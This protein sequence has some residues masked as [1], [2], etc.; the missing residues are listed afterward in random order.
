MPLRL[1]SAAEWQKACEGPGGAGVAKWS[2]TNPTTYVPN[3]CNDFKN[4]DGNAASVV[5]SGVPGQELRLNGL[6]GFTAADVGRS[7]FITG[8]A[9]A[10]WNNKTFTIAAVNSST[11]VNLTFAGAVAL[12][13]NNPNIVW[14]V[15]PPVWTTGHAGS[16]GMCYTDW[17]AAGQIHDLSGNLSEWTGTPVID[18]GITYYK[19]R[20]GAYDTPPGG[21]T[22]E[23]DFELGQ[24][25]FANADV[26]FRCCADNPSCG[27]VTSDPNNCGT[28][29]NVCPAV[30]SNSTC[31]PSCD[32][33]LT[34]CSNA[35]VN[36]MT[37][38]NNC[39]ACTTSSVSHACGNGQT[40]VAGVCTCPTGMNLCSGVCV[41]EQTDPNHCGSCTTICSG[42]T[43]DCQAGVCSGACGGATPTNCSGACVNTTS[44]PNHCGSCTNVCGAGSQCVSGACCT[45]T[46]CSGQCVNTLTDGTNCGTCGTNCVTLLGANAT[47]QNGMCC[48][49]GFVNCGGTCV[50][51]STNHDNCNACGNVCPVG[52]SC[53]NGSCCGAGLLTCGAQCVNPASDNN[54]C[55]DCF[56]VCPSN[57][58]CTACMG[59][60]CPQPGGCCAAGQT[61]CSGTCVDT[62]TNNNNCGGC[63]IQCGGGASCKNG[64]C[65]CGPYSS[66]CS[67]T[68]T[69]AAA[70][71]GL[72]LPQANINV[73]STKGFSNLGGTISVTTGAGV[74]TVT[75]QR[76]VGNQFQGC[77]GGT[78]T[79]S[80]GGAVNNGAAQCIPT[81]VDPNNCGGCGIVCGAGTS[82]SNGACV[83]TCNANLFQFTTLLNACSQSCVDQTD[84]RI[85]CGGS[86]SLCP[87]GQGCN[88]GVCGAGIVPFVKDPGGIC[89]ANGLGPIILLTTNGPPRTGST[90]SGSLA[91]TT[92]TFGMCGCSNF[93]G[94]GS[95]AVDGWDSEVDPYAVGANSGCGATPPTGGCQG[96]SFG[97]NASAAISSSLTIS[98]DLVGF[99]NVSAG[100]AVSEQVHIG[101]SDAGGKGGNTSGGLA[102]VKIASNNPGWIVGNG[103]GTTI[104][105]ATNGKVLPQATITVVSTTGFSIPGTIFV[106]SSAGVQTVTCTGST[107]T[108]FTGCSGG[109]GTMSTGGVVSIFPDRSMYVGANP[110]NTN[111]TC[112]GYTLSNGTCNIENPFTLQKPCKRCDP[113]SQIPVNAYITNY[114]GTNNDNAGIGLNA[115]KF[116]AGAP[117]YVGSGILD[118]P[119]GYYFLSRID[120]AGNLTIV[121]HGNTALFV[122]GDIN[123]GP[124]TG[125]TISEAPGARLDLFVGGAIALQGSPNLG[126]SAY[127]ANQRTYVGCSTSGTCKVNTDCCSSGTGT[128][129]CSAAPT[130]STTIAAASNGMTLPQATIN[131][132]S[133][134]N[135]PPF[136]TIQVTT[137]AGAQDVSYTG[138][139]ATSFTGC[140]GGSGTM[141]TGGAV[142]AHTC[143]SN[144][145]AVDI[146]NPNI[147]VGGYYAPNGQFAMHGNTNMAGSIF[148]NDFQQVSGNFNLHY[149]KA[150]A[151]EDA[152]CAP[153]TGMGC[154]SC[155]DCSN[156]ACTGAPGSM[157]CGGCTADS[158]CCSPLRCV[159]PMGS[160]T[161][162][163]QFTSF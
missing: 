57:T 41:I 148:T 114:S 157:T 50:D 49:A 66:F 138:L 81:S 134:T 91:A 6:V 132:A 83:G 107:A 28:C 37:D 122:Q 2:T 110:P 40:C 145:P 143:T 72:T 26:G 99:G 87:S 159:I 39:G 63:G 94:G 160:T 55:G 69:L 64:M 23:F 11:S 78:G 30:C 147:F 144:N 119:C 24:Q 56:Q 111:T 54:N 153:P 58:M 71:N 156:Q 150:F 31:K 89:G 133:T 112:A 140:T 108:S 32:A 130:A 14:S 103:A 137:S 43:P 52:N 82:C 73:A 123:S 47:C 61:D 128:G 92:F 96:G 19:V 146:H 33:G 104:T 93:N 141:S 3:V 95:S 151:N 29:G 77:A 127:P 90:C 25:G 106:T 113:A 86:C 139:T 38:A 135:F 18:S 121:A 163:C 62:T 17:A 44:D 59:A 35:C 125:L 51:L 20:G 124:G 158:Q 60:G 1:C 8:A 162:T 88:Q 155:L 9:N 136:G 42:A 161:G 80:T 120:V 46:V 105:A 118:L 65:K 98:G 70:S 154:M 13:A 131:V 116:K 16:A 68:T 115:D 100:F 109:T 102:E 117:G 84:D 21:T 12:D 48:A 142:S 45:Q 149:D 152:V 67:G 15:S 101:G 129:T 79:M 34:N 5:S 53:V 85:Y 36:T 75:Y 10:A 126:N 4:G 22:C 74:Q 76:I 27:D 7:V 97:I